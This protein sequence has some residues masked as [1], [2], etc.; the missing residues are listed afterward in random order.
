MENKINLNSQFRT[1]I[2]KILSYDPSVTS[3]FGR[4]EN[5]DAFFR[6]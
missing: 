3:I 2:V 6:I 4:D 5:K 1:V